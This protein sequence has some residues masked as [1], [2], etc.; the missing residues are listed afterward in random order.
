[1]E[2]AA[3][4]SIPKAT[5]GPS[6]PF[7]QPHAYVDMSEGRLAR[8]RF[9][10]GP[11]VVMIHGW[12]LNAAT[13]RQL[14]P[15]LAPD[16]TLHL[17]DLPGTGHSLQ[18]NGAID[19]ETHARTVRRVIDSL[20]LTRYALLSH[21]SGGV[22][23]RLIAAEDARVAGLILSG[24]A[25]PGHRP[26]L[27]REYRLASKIPGSGV[28]IRAAMRRRAVR[29]SFIGFG[30]CFRDPD[31]MEGEFKDLFLSPILESK[32]AYQGQMQLVR[33][34]DFA[35]IDRLTTAHARI[36]APVFCIWGSED[37]FFPVAKARAMLAQ[38]HGKVELVEIPGAKLFAHED[39][40]DVFAAH[41]LSFLKSIDW[42]QPPKS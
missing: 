41:C 25:I 21:D 2:T 18:W 1:M 28:L 16:F 5:P 36:R 17:F 6:T 14:V 26:P 42:S 23:A 8:W 27:I 10:S 20:A 32:L 33:N 12:P 7:K 9:G 24:S 35:I 11:D 38:F 22:I 31:F 30:G 39:H 19:L 40:P 15:K 37:P 13:F 29:R 34:L 4:Q 3:A